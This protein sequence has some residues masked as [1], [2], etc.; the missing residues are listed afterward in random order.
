M[1]KL[2]LIFYLHLYL[3]AVNICAKAFIKLALSKCIKRAMD[4][5][6][7][8]IMIDDIFCE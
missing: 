8:I 6:T 4:L 3:N 2:V 5:V 7:D 1:K